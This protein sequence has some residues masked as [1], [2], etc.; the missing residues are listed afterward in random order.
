MVLLAIGS[1]ACALA[2]AQACL[3]LAG[4]PRERL[5]CAALGVLARPAAW[6]ARLA[7]D[8]RMAARKALAEGGSRALHGWLVA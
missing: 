1:R 4:R 2:L 5:A 7:D 8:T 6:P 3:W